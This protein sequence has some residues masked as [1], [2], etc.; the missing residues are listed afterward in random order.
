MFNCCEKLLRV[1]GH[2]I[3]FSQEKYTSYLRQYNFPNLP[4]AYPYYWEKDHFANSLTCKKAPVSYMEDLSVFR[5]K[6][7]SDS[8]HP[9]RVYAQELL[10]QMGVT[11]KQIER[12]LGHR[13]AEHFF[14][15]NNAS[16]FGLCT[17]QTYLELINEYHINELP[18][19]KPY[20]ELQEIDMK[21][22]PIFNLN[23]ENT[24]GN[25]LKYKKPYNYFHP[26]EKPVDLLEDLIK[27]YTHEGDLVLDFTMGSGSTG[28]A[29]MN[30]NR[31]FIGIELEEKYYNIAEQR[32]KEATQ[33]KQ[34]T[35]S[36]W[37]G[38][39]D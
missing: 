34:T 11:F 10:N 8:S 14:Y 2:L 28:V 17:E 25:I 33:S 23:G 7:D 21:F 20:V 31:K 32:L 5:K 36:L 1:N 22:K 15:S 13:K 30:L 26:T 24:K 38:G 37:C 6:Y 4:F 9:L 18:C 27:T 19:F 3:L 39:D 35:L 29:C 16:Q 12:Q